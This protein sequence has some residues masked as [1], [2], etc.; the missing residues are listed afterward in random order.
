M[1]PRNDLDPDNDHWHWLAADLRVWRLERNMTQ[2]ALGEILGVTKTQVSNWESAREN[3]P[4]KHAETL[5]LVWRT[6]G[7]FTRLRRLAE[8]AH[9]P[10]WWSQYTPLE[11]R[12]S[13]VSYW[14]L[15]IIPGLL[16]TEDYA[17]ALMEDGQIIENVEDA[18]SARM[19]RQGILTREKPPELRVLINE[20][21][22]DQPVG[23][24]EVMRGQLTHLIAISH[25]RNVILQVVPRDVGAHIGLDGS[26][27]LLTGARWSAA[28]ME[29]NTGGRLTHEPASVEDF[30]K[31]LDLIRS[32]ALSASASRSHI[33]RIME[34][35]K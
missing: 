30:G 19:A 9:D 29:A 32:E 17:R 27:T 11:A 12:A 8:R 2:P 3:L 34:A 5:D 13:R 16:Q 22:L 15:A 35:M 24:V 1:P 33:G 7:H 28:Y 10:G 21:A 31:R 26:F 18:V 4:M 6:A 25:A 20:G 23:G 14:A